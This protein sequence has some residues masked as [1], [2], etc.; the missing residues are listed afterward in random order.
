MPSKTENPIWW[1]VIFIVSFIHIVAAG[2]FLHTPHQKTVYLLFV[3]WVLGGLGITMGYH[4]LW[5]HRSYKAHPIL[6]LVLSLM[7][8]AAFQGSIK[9]WSL[10]H[11]L[12]HRY[13]DTEHD[14]YDATK[15]FWHSHLGW[16]FT[17]PEYTR[18]KWIDKSDLIADPIVRF[19]HKYYPELTILVG[20][21]L[22]T[23]L[24]YIWGDALGGFLYGGYLSRILIWHCT[25]FINSLAHTWGEQEYSI[26]NTSRGNLLLA[27]L[28]FGEGHHNYHHEFP[29]DYRNGIRFSHYDPTKWAIVFCT[30]IGLSWNLIKVPQGVILK[31]RIT[32]AQDKIDELKK[33]LI[34]EG[35]SN[36]L[37]WTMAEYYEEAK[38]ND[39]IL[40][41][42]FVIDVKEF[43]TQHPGGSK[44]L[45]NYIGKD[46]TKSFYGVLN[47]HTKSARQ[48]MEDMRVAKV[49]KNVI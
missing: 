14:P 5:S 45:T 1:S 21:V 19:Q 36:L 17:K 8:V 39:L 13:T 25:W 28:T 15:G 49:D 3:T 41:D 26:E 11:R 34:W 20:F 18:L 7:G 38:N 46:A 30:Y 27:L 23:A 31:A 32:T 29:R 43:K 9:W 10:R 40:I 47:N 22:P 48:M 2:A 42:G 24:G 37:R 33:Q 44:L 16:M 6:R 12:H 35:S 4:R